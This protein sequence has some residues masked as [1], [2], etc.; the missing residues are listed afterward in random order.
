MPHMDTPCHPWTGGRNSD[1]YGYCK[2]NG[3]MLRAGRVAWESTHG[4]IPTGL[5]LCHRCDNPPCVRLDH[6][7]LDTQQGNVRDCW[8]KGRHQAIPGAGD[9]KRNRTHCPHGHPY[10]GSNLY[11]GTQAGGRH[12]R[13]KCRACGRIRAQAT[14]DR[15]K[16]GQSL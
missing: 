11:L 8:A 6:A 1:G 15:R 12:Q 14:R 3:R 2:V 7:W 16:A 10:T 13:R 9:Y 4:P 5:F